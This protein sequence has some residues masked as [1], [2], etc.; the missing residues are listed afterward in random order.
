MDDIVERYKASTPN[1]SRL[2]ARSAQVIA[3]GVS[4]NFGYHIPY[5][6]VNARGA[7]AR[8]EDV[9]GNVYIDTAYNGLS[10]IHGHAPAEL[11]REIEAAIA[12]GWAWPGTSQA[13][14]D[15]GEAL[16]KR[17]PGYDKVRFTNSG[18]EAMMLA[19]K[20][21]R[22]ATKRPLLLK[23]RAAYHGSYP[24]LE[25]GLH[26]TGAIEGRTIV[27]DFGDT[28]GFI[29]AIRENRDRLAAVLIEPVLVT[30][31]IVPPPEGFLEAITEA[32]R[33]NDVLVILDDCLMFR[34][35]PAGSLEFFDIEADLMVLG[36]FIG[37]G[38]P[39]G[40]VLGQDSVM[41]VLSDPDEP[42][43]HGGSF[44]GNLLACRAGLKSLE[45][46]SPDSIDRMNAQA[47]EIKRFLQSNNT[48]QNYSPALTGVGSVVGISFNESE[49]DAKD[50]LTTLNR[51]LRFHLSCLLSGVQMGAGGII[52][53]ATA[54]DD[55]TVE[56][57]KSR[58]DGAIQ[59]FSETE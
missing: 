10:L 6:V 46:L 52:S 50:Y 53:L 2:M 1:S 47:A 5:P 3:G 31:A 33:A 51:N 13:Q 14:I 54:F 25:A 55:D 36:K 45:M 59:L 39:M 7:G 28:D 43:Y 18:T 40:A 37:G 12:D 20:I 34:L 57:L 23:A 41:R 49:A 24:D 44:N 30:G 42:L 29:E 56:D 4:R 35:A 58:L 32:A 22:R 38:V 21:A 48:L 17:I 15:F 11:L 8:I 9:D 19:V 26:G 16:L 27:R